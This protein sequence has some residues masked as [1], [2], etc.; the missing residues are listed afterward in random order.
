LWHLIVLKADLAEH[1]R[2]IKDYFLLAKGEFYQTFLEEARSI[3]S[4]PPQSSAEYDLNIGPLQQTIIKLGL[5][6]DPH[7]KKF[8][9]KLR[10]FSFNYSDFSVL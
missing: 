1:L 7:L 5:E 4:L 2:S 9:L 10:S 6:E 8:K 3:M